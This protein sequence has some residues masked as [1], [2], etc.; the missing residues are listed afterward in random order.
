M[1]LALARWVRPEILEDRCLG[2]G[3]EGQQFDSQEGGGEAGG[4]TALRFP[5]A[6]EAFEEGFVVA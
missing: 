4:G 6:L 5:S 1:K 3:L 2:H